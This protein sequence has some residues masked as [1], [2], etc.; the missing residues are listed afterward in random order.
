[1][2]SATCAVGGSTTKLGGDR[3]LVDQVEEAHLLLPLHPRGGGRRETT[4]GPCLVRRESVRRAGEA[5][6]T[7]VLQVVELSRGGNRQEG[8]A[9]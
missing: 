9:G 7:F 8:D 6:P 5:N 1:M 3:G 4:G 2:K